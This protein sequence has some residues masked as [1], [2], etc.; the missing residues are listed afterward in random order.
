MK[1]T[2]KEVNQ[3]VNRLEGE[4]LLS[5]LGTSDLF[6]PGCFEALNHCTRI[7]KLVKDAANLNRLMKTESDLT[8]V[9]SIYLGMLV[10]FAIS[11][12]RQGLP[13]DQVITEDDKP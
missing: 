3:A 10:G 6:E 13:P 7:R 12:L 9:D 5:Q 11:K 2:C 4:V 1:F 8:A